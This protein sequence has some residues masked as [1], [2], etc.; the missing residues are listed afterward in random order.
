[1]GEEFGAN[2]RVSPTCCRGRLE[3]P[4]GPGE[5]S[6]VEFR[7]PA[8]G[9]Y[10]EASVLRRL[11]G[12]AASAPFQQEAPQQRGGAHHLLRDGLCCPRLAHSWRPRV[13]AAQTATRVPASS[14]RRLPSKPSRRSGSSFTQSAP[15]RAFAKQRRFIGEPNLVANTAAASVGFAITGPRLTGVK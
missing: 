13:P 15:A 2:A 11:R 1:M 8:L 10:S 7:L 6:R 9:A 5:R 12:V 3:A 4:R 14:R